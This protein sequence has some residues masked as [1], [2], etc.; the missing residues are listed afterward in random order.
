MDPTLFLSISI[1]LDMICICSA[2]KGKILKVLIFQKFFI[3]TGKNV[4]LTF[5]ER[6]LCTQIS[7]LL[8][9]ACSSS[10]FMWFISFSPCMYLHVLTFSNQSRAQFYTS[11][12][13]PWKVS[14]II[15][16]SFFLWILG[17]LTWLISPYYFVFGFSFPF[18]ISIN[19]R[20]KIN[21]WKP[22]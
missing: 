1:S 11:I 13:H 8:S 15:F 7:R 14:S 9:K 16:W 6:M 19:S 21:N 3:C 2:E 4:V 17:S 12:L 5:V 18:L 22:I 20:S 10:R